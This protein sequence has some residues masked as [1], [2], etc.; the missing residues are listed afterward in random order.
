MPQLNFADFSP[1]VVWLVITFAVLYA[2]LSWLVLPRISRTLG[3]RDARLT[4]DIARAEQLR[5][6]AESTL[7][8]YEKAM[9]EAREKAQAEIR[10]AA[11]AM[12]AEAHRR[13]SELAAGLAARTKAAEAGIA[14][15][16]RAALGELKTV[17]AEAARELVLRLSGTAPGSAELD[18]A[19][20]AAG[21]ER[22]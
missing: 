10:Q 22:A 2:L 21:G 4:G 11:Q 12:A 19:I 15:A 20:G 1:Q 3:E 16:K 9:A 18:A 13:E 5:A 14:E 8:A 17:A 7:A 6:E